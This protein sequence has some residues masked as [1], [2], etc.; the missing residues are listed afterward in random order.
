MPEEVLDVDHI[1][2]A[3][4]AYITDNERQYAAR[5]HAIPAALRSALSPFFDSELL[6][7]VR[8]CVLNPGEQVSD[9]DFLPALRAMGFHDLPSSALSEAI[10]FGRV[11]VSR[12]PLSEGGLFHE[13]VHCVEFELLGVQEFARHYVSGFLRSGS[14]AGSPL[15]ECAYELAARF[16]AHPDQPFSVANEVRSW[17]ERI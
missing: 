13:S 4:A 15:E 14:Y 12:R 2:A 1:A 3:L 10:T 16:E 5:G 17:I 11:I 9:P 7:R 8:L 6:D